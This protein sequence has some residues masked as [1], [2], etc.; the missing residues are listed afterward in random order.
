[1]NKIAKRCLL[2]AM[3][4]IVIVALPSCRSMQVEL[5]AGKNRA[6]ESVQEMVHGSFYGYYWCEPH[7]LKDRKAYFGKVNVSLA[8]WQA[9]VAVASIGLYVPMSTEYWLNVTP[10]DKFGDEEK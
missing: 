2:V 9:L 6:D 7:V 4:G 10:E 3:I 5:E 8:P 1:M